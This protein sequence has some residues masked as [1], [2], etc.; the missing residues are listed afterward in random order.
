V[1]GGGRCAWRGPV[2]IVAGFAGIVGLGVMLFQPLLVGGYVPGL[3][4]RPGRRAH[5]WIGGVP[6]VA[7]VIHRAGL[8]IT[9]PPDMIDALLFTS[10]TPFHPSA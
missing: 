8:W 2:Y 7:V 10:P 1:P 5:R 4:G 6:V 9:T 3:P